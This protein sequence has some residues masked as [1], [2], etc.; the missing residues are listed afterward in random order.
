V[1]EHLSLSDVDGFASGLLAGDERRRVVT[2]L[3]SGCHECARVL[4]V[5]AGL[6]GAPASHTSY[7]AAITR[8]SE[9]V[10]ASAKLDI[11]AI[12]TAVLSGQRTWQALSSHEL[13]ALQGV[14]QVR[15]LLQAGRSLRHQDPEATLRFASL[16]RYAADRLDPQKF[17]RAATADL[18]ALAWAELANAHRLGDDL[19]AASRAMNRAIHWFRHGTCAPL[20]IARIADLT[21]SLLGAQR[22][23]VEGQKILA[24]AQQVYLEE[25]Q[26]HLAGRAL[27]KAGNLAAID[28]MPGKGI[29]LLQRGLELI[30]PEREPALVAQTL[31]TMIWWLCDMGHFRSARRLLWRSRVLFVRDSNALDLLRLRWLEGRIYAGLSDFARAETAFQ[32]T[33]SG[34]AAKGQIYPAALAG[35]D[36]AAL[37]TRQGRAAE[38]CALAEEMIGTFRALH[39]AREAIAA[40]V[41]VKHVCS[42]ERGRRVLD[43]IRLVVRFLEELEQ[44][45]VRNH[46]SSGTGVSTSSLPLS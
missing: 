6:T 1:A 43:V 7:D 5:A 45:P 34:F 21:A 16:A 2:H 27:I 23:L 18:R 42:V 37:W 31:R 14:P 40:L 38:V 4:A 35:L 33:R 44:Q 20:L 39:I 25:G 24:L 28:G 17:G 41:M 13:T 9:R 36:L 26:D 22:R 11:V 15:A 19:A 32:E 29:H 8:A 3:L 10:R 30:E 46:S 12:L